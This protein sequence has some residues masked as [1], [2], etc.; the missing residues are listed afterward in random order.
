MSLRAYSSPKLG[1][2]ERLFHSSLAGL[3]SIL[4]PTRGDKSNG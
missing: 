3:L 1:E 2:G 4:F